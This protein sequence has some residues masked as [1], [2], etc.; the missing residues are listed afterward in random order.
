MRRVGLWRFQRGRPGFAGVKWW[1]KS[2]GWC[3]RWLRGAALEDEAGWDG[4][5]WALCR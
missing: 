5:I 2:R 1:Q 4:G 3:W